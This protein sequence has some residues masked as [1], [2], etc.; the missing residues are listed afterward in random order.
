M[1][2][3]GASVGDFEGLVVGLVDGGGIDGD[4]DGLCVGCIIE[5][6]TISEQH[7]SIKA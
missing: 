5:K 4:F 1:P 3:I 6:E 7:V 2:I